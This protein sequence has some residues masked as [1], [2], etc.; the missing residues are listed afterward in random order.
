MY[1]PNTLLSLKKRLE[2]SPFKYKFKQ[3]NTSRSDGT[4]LQPPPSKK[5]KRNKREN[6]HGIVLKNNSPLDC[7]SDA[8]CQTRKLSNVSTNLQ[9]VL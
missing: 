2:K 6:K 8:I 5:K 7:L 1:L 3:I 9:G 4:Q